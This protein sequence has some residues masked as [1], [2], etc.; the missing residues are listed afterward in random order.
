MDIFGTLKTIID[1][2]LAG[3]NVT[4][5][6]ASVIAVTGISLT[7]AGVLLKSNKALLNFRRN[8]HL[9]KVME[10]RSSALKSNINQKAFNKY[11]KASIDLA[12][13]EKNNVLK[14]ELKIEQAKLFNKSPNKVYRLEKRLQIAKRS[15]NAIVNIANDLT[16]YQDA[17]VTKNGLKITVPNYIKTSSNLVKDQYIQSVNNSSYE[18]RKSGMAAPYIM[19]VTDAEGKI[20]GELSDISPQRFYEYVNKMNAILYSE[21]SERQNNYNI[22]VYDTFDKSAK[23]RVLSHYVTSESDFDNFTSNLKK[24]YLDHEVKV[25]T[26][27]NRKAKPVIAT[28]FANVQQNLNNQTNYV[29]NS[30]TMEY[31]KKLKLIENLMPE[32]VLYYVDSNPDTVSL[33]ESEYFSKRVSEISAKYSLK[34][35]KYPI[36][37]T[38]KINNSEILSYKSESKNLHEAL[39]YYLYGYAIAISYEMN[40]ID[41]IPLTEGISF[42][43][44]TLNEKGLLEVKKEKTFSSSTEVFLNKGEFPAT[45]QAI[46]EISKEKGINFNFQNMEQKALKLQEGTKLQLQQSEQAES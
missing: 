7:A 25:I 11:L 44:S 35:K 10:Y 31:E 46:S 24:W 40:D 43:Y 19:K 9:T 32:K 21:V 30:Q 37:T 6:I 42:E 41:G 20:V 38:L 26:P 2:I 14:L 3:Y 13:R 39:K 18:V 27:D 33:L 12:R 17:L 1:G 29:Q 8:R 34:E 45:R 28:S 23:T 36:V 5:I 4:V 16:V 22:V 15:D